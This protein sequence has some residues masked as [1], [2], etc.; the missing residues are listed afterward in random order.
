MLVYIRVRVF[1]RVC[2]C[3][4]VCTCTCVYLCASSA[5]IYSP[6]PVEAG[7]WQ[8]R[9]ATSALKPFSWTVNSTAIVTVDSSVN[10]GLDA[11]SGDGL[12]SP[13]SRWLCVEVLL[14]GSASWIQ[15]EGFLHRW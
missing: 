2:V 6:F 11:A 9:A 3:A 4:H 8:P 14:Q 13:E 1:K 7:E 10:E 12:L 15:D 5:Q